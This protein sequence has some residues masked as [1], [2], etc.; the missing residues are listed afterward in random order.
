M[1]TWIVQPSPHMRSKLTTQRVMLD[2]LIALFPALVAGVVFFGPR[3][4][5]LIAV[6]VSASISFEYLFNFITKRE[7]TIGDLSAVVTG[8]LLAFNLPV[9]LPFYMAIIGCFVAIVIV[10]M[11]FGGI[12]QNFANPA[13]TARIVLMLSFASSMTSWTQPFS[14]LPSAA[15]VSSTATPLDAEVLPS[16]FDL[17]IGNHAGCI[18]ET[19]AFAL[20]LGGVYLVARKIIHPITPIAFVGTVAILF[21]C[22]GNQPVEVLAYILSGG[23]ILGAVF[24]ATDYATTPVTD[25]GKLIFGI[26]CGAITVLIR[27]FGMVPEGVSYS[28]LLMN[29]LTPYIDKFTRPRAFGTKTMKKKEWNPKSAIPIVA[30]SIFTLVLSSVLIVSYNLTYKDT[31]GMTDKLQEACESLMGEGEYTIITDWKAAGYAIDKPST[32]QKLI[33]KD[34][35]SIAFEI[36]TKGYSKNGIDA[37]I[38]MNPDGSIKGVVLISVTDTPGLGTKVKDEDFLSKFEGINGAVTVT[39][40]EAQNEN[41]VQAISGATYSSKGVVTGV[42]I[43]LE[44]YQQMM[45]GESVGGHS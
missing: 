35:G 19:S 43:A 25:K 30:L 13:I 11:L 16:L 40:F 21:F 27:S 17:F 7:Q 31:S 4:L 44:V 14:Y 38:A 23:L 6:C 26:G 9:S 15:D 29:I 22:M 12:G 8:V 36:V 5:L 10:K 3:A 45:S 2:V 1:K 37:L 28:I 39:K 32:V 24:M 34:D 18:G 20:L 33:Q 42:N 41:E